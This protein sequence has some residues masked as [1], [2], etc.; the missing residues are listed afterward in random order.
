MF[1]ITYKL[2]KCVPVF[3]RFLFKFLRIFGCT[4][5]GVQWNMSKAI[6]L[7]QNKWYKY[8][9]LIIGILV[10]I[11]TLFETIMLIFNMKK[12]AVQLFDQNVDHNVMLVYLVFR[13]METFY[14]FIVFYTLNVKH[15]FEIIRL[16]HIHISSIKN[17][18]NLKATLLFIYLIC[19]AVLLIGMFVYVTV[20]NVKSFV[21]LFSI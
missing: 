12:V 18:I 21:I 4:F 5:C 1:K 3:I 17:Y 10:N 11:L 20:S 6:V 7:E 9:G 16:I 2:N 8:Y 19:L 14:K 13:V 15:G